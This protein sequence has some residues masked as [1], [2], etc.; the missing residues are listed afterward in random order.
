MI[1]MT[2]TGKGGLAYHRN[3]YATAPHPFG[4]IACLFFMDTKV[5]QGTDDA[6]G[7]CSDACPR[8]C[9]D[10]RSGGITGP[11]PGMAKA[12]RPTRSRLAPK[13]RPSAR[14]YGCATGA[15]VSTFRAVFPI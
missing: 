5:R 12:S 3:E 6:A 10:E 8:Q 11:I 15:I 4:L 9:G 13:G 1:G 14:F 2:T 7:S